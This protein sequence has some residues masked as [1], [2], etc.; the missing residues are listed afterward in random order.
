MARQVLAAPAATCGGRAA[1]GRESRAEDELDGARGQAGVLLDGHVA[2]QRG[3]RLRGRQVGTGRVLDD[4]V[5]VVGRAGIGNSDDVGAARRQATGRARCQAS[6]RS[7]IGTT[8]F[9]WA[10]PTVLSDGEGN[11]DG[12]ER[13]PLAVWAAALARDFAGSFVSCAVAANGASCLTRSDYQPLKALLSRQIL[14]LPVI[15][16]NVP[17]RFDIAELPVGVLSVE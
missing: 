1:Q 4:R 3:K 17:A 13:V 16:P 7:A 8:T 15:P 11:G 2:D 12:V 10:G 14:T 6:S 9:T 5:R